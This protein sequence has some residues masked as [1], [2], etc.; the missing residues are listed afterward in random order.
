M[1]KIFPKNLK[2]EM[3]ISKM[4][5]ASSPRT[6]ILEGPDIYFSAGGLVNLTCVVHS[7]IQPGRIFWYHQVDR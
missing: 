1:E 7:A 2:Y 3:L 4:L 6:T 5:E